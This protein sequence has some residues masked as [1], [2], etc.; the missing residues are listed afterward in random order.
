MSLLDIHKYLPKEE[1]GKVSET[2]LLIERANELESTRELLIRH[3]SLYIPSD[4]ATSIKIPCPWRFEHKDGGKD[5]GMRYYFDTDSAFC[6][7]DHGVVDPVY[8]NSMVWGETRKNTA[9]IMLE[10]AG[11]LKRD[12]YSTRMESLLS[13]QVQTQTANQQYALEALNM[14]LRDVP[15]YVSAQFNSAVIAAKNLCME[16]FD[17][18]WTLSDIEKWIT[19]SVIYIRQVSEKHAKERFGQMV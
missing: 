12:H 15:E 13:A 3:F 18:Q 2:A 19:A 1:Q 7:R 17:P 8:I 14:A 6:F 16:R 10:R 4:G 5:K 11:K 9:K